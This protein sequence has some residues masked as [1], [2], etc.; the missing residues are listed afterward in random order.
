MRNKIA[1]LMGASVIVPFAGMISAHCYIP[2][3]VFF[4]EWK[5]GRYSLV[6]LSAAPLLGVIYALWLN[7]RTR[8]NSTI[9]YVAGIATALALGLNLFAA[10]FLSRFK[11][12]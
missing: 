7:H 1:L 10:F 9:I 3:I 5:C 8:T 11:L 4:Y 12:L 6:P 2:S